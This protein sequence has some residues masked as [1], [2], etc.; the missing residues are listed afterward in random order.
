MIATSTS[1]PNVTPPSE[2]HPTM[3]RVLT[4]PTTGPLTCTRGQVLHLVRR[5]GPWSVVRHERGGPEVRILTDLVEVVEDADRETPLAGF[6]PCSLALERS[7]QWFHGRISR[8]TAEMILR[9]HGSRNGA[10]LIRE[11]THFPG[12]F[13]LSLSVDSS[14]GPQPVHFRIKRE[15]SEEGVKL[16]LGDG[17]CFDNLSDVIK[18]FHQCQG[19]L[20]TRLYKYCPKRTTRLTFDRE[21]F[22]RDGWILRSVFPLGFFFPSWF[23]DPIAERI[24][25]RFDDLQLG[26]ELGSGEFGV[27]RQGTYKGTQV[28]IKVLT[29]HSLP[30]CITHYLVYTGST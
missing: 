5:E 18:C 20:P 9:Q 11:S 8:E 29:S 7:Q 24:L 27:V 16:G 13:T 1:L 19:A 26:R 15:E 21:V 30:L 14:D 23:Y 25:G 22:A 28:A 10:F 17:R 6:G 4:T 2:T 3:L 12:D